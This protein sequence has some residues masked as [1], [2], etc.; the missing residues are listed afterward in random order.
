[1]SVWRFIVRHDLAARAPRFTGVLSVRLYSL[2]HNTVREFEGGTVLAH[3][4][5]ECSR[6]HETPVKRGARAAKDQ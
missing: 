2:S 4:E 3:G 5:G 1:M 6:T